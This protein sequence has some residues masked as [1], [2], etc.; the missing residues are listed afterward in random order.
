VCAAAA[1]HSGPSP[2]AGSSRMARAGNGPSGRTGIEIPARDYREVS[3]LN[4]RLAHL[5]ARGAPV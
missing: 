5:S 1:S 4:G 3:T 2:I